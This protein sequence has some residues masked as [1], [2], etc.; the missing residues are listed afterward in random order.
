MSSMPSNNVA[1]TP[2]QTGVASEPSTTPCTCPS[3]HVEHVAA[4]GLPLGLSTLVQ[5]QD[6]P[7]PDVYQPESRQ[8]VGQDRRRCVDS[9]HQC[10]AL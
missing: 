8:A 3:F 9:G 7:L 6:L 1:A 5:V 10:G 4:W 2:S